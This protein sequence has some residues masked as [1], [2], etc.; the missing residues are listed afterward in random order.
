MLPFYKSPL[1][2]RCHTSV[3]LARAPM[4]GIP[5]TVQQRSE[6]N[7][8]PWLWNLKEEHKREYTKKRGASPEKFYM[9]L[10]LLLR[11]SQKVYYT[12][13]KGKG[14]H[15]ES[16]TYLALNIYFLILTLLEV[17]III[18]ILQIENI[19]FSK[20]NHSYLY[21]KRKRSLSYVPLQLKDG[22]LWIFLS[23]S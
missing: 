3:F 10:F 7:T 9:F 11:H 20:S 14:I 15:S 2:H 12:K 19:G 21:K 23:T 16:V 6:G 17:N 13:W 22:Y 18:L 5:A 8:T 1:R 4:T